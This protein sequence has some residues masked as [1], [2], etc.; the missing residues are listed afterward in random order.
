VLFKFDL[1]WTEIIG[2]VFPNTWK[3]FVTDG[4]EILITQDSCDV[5]QT[6]LKIRCFVNGI[7]RFEFVFI[8][9]D[10]ASLEEAVEKAEEQLLLYAQQTINHVEFFMERLDGKD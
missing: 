1:K 9:E 10:L 4:I 5:Y 6:T 8:D 7:A 2:P 3:A